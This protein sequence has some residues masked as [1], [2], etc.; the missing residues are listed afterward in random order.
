[1]SDLTC[2]NCG[3]AV[4]EQISYVTMVTCP[5]CSTTLYLDGAQLRNAGQ[6]G[7]MHDGPSLFGIGDTVHFGG[8]SVQIMGHA[9]YSYGRGWWDE[10]WGLDEDQRGVWVS[11]DEGDVVL[12]YPIRQ[13]M[14]PDIPAGAGVGMAWEHRDET[15]RVAEADKAEC[16]ALRGS[17]G[18][19]L[20]V[21][22]TY[23]FLNLQSENGALM[24]GEFWQGGKSWYLGFWHDPFD[25]RVEALP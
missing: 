14:W 24:S 13:E 9:R 7:E 4:P 1:M 17:F 15:W 18:E 25:I 6:S 8:N 19:Q 11:V 21:G 5:S 12:Q 16:V 3:D 22:E 20:T 10:F 23:R 2:P